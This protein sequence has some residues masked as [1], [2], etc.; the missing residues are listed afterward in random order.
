MVQHLD[1]NTNNVQYTSTW[2]KLGIKNKNHATTTPTGK[3]IS[4]PNKTIIRTISNSITRT[5]SRICEPQ[6][7]IE[8]AITNLS[9]ADTTTNNFLK[10]DQ[11]RNIHGKRSL[12]TPES[13]IQ[14]TVK[15]IKHQ[16]KKAEAI[17]EN[18]WKSSKENKLIWEDRQ[19]TA[20]K[21]NY[22]SSRAMN[23]AIINIRLKAPANTYVAVPS[24]SSI[25]LALTEE[26]SWEDF[27]IIFRSTTVSNTKPDGTYLIPIFSGEDT[28][29]H[30]SFVVVHKTFR[31]RRMWV[32]DS[33]GTGHRI[34]TIAIKKA[35]SIGRL[36]CRLIE[37]KS[38]A[39]VEV[40][41][42]PRAVTGMV[43]I[44]ETLRKGESIDAAI[45]AGSLELPIVNGYDSENVRRL[46]AEWV[47]ETELTKVQHEAREVI[48]RRYCSRRRRQ[49]RQR[50]NADMVG[51]RGEK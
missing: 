12:P 49:R 26:S 15:F 29:G 36:K 41:C 16:G 25:I 40:E 18:V 19:Q 27:A 7:R 33:L 39:Q 37:S 28:R 9:K 4:D 21:G 35:F 5:T 20:T 44:C 30:W 34:A 2:A 3:R 50:Q 46:A 8:E 45:L 6:Q 43:S 38:R 51:G 31:S 13:E 10:I 47:L 1:N 22:M 11:Q 14:K 32:M 23:R 17:E 48:F 24:A 42:G